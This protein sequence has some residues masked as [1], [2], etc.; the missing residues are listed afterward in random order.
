[1]ATYW[2]AACPAPDGG[3]EAVVQGAK[4][5][6]VAHCSEFFPLDCPHNLTFRSFDSLIKHL[7]DLMKFDNQVE[8]TLRRF[9]KAMVEFPGTPEFA[10][11]SQ[12]QTYPLKKYM[13]QFVWDDAKFPKKRTISENLA[14]MMA[15]VSKLDDEVRNKLSALGELKSAH[16]QVSKKEN[17]SLQSRELIDVLTPS[18]VQA[19]DFVETEHLTTVV[20][21]VPQGGDKE[22]MA[23]YMDMA[24]FLVPDSAKKLAGIEKDKE[25]NVLY[26]VVL[27]KSALEDFKAAARQKRFTVREFVFSVAKYAEYE[28]KRKKLEEEVSNQ[29]SL[30]KMICR[31]AFSDTFVAWMHVKMMR[32][33]VESVLRFGVGAD[34]MPRFAAFMLLPQSLKTEKVVRTELTALAAKYGVKEDAED[35]TADEEFFPYVFLT[36]TPLSAQ[37]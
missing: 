19:S 35:K 22:F 23:T 14:V 34:G 2:I 11:V 10:I 6:L 5:Q 24:D 15:T 18:K 32:T 29:E 36:M 20:V 12:R 13:Q 16:G 26:R 17:V 3:A 25:Q 31:A 7:D 37:D 33:F 30:C 27:F 9:E 28:E 8:S 1:M 21:V 4:Q